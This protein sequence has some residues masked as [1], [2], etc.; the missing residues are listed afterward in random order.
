MFSPRPLSKPVIDGRR[1]ESERTT[2]SIPSPVFLNHTW[3]QEPL[4]H[5]S[6]PLTHTHTTE[7][8]FTQRLHCRDV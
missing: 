8:G 2:M 3:S 7:C 6:I 5:P 1:E 4:G